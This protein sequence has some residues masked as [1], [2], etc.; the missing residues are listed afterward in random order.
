VA[1]AGL[2]NAR[3]RSY[4]QMPFVGISAKAALRI[5]TH[6]HGSRS[7]KRF[8]MLIAVCVIAASGIPVKTLAQSPPAPVTGIKPDRTVAEPATRKAMRE[9]R[10]ALRQKLAGCRMQARQQRISPLKRRAFIR[11]CMARP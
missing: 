2:D 4:P 5:N 10:L 8:A 1:G 7:M 11:D 3:D 9:R 6:R